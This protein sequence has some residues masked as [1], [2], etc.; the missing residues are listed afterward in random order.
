[1][2]SKRTVWLVIPLAVI[3]YPR[4]SAANLVDDKIDIYDGMDEH[5]ALY[6]R[7]RTTLHFP[8]PPLQ[9]DLGDSDNYTMKRSLDGLRA[10]IDVNPNAGPTNLNVTFS[11]ARG[12]LRLSVVHSPQ[13]ARAAYRLQYRNKPVIKPAPSA[14]T[15]PSIDW[16]SSIVSVQTPSSV[17]WSGS[18][19]TLELNPG[20]I[21]ETRDDVWMP[22]EV[23]NAGD[24]PFPVAR[25]ELL[26]HRQRIVSSAEVVKHSWMVLDDA[27]A[28]R[29]VGQGE[30]ARFTF[31]VTRPAAI[32]RGWAVRIVSSTGIKPA[33]F[34]WTP[35]TERRSTRGGFHDRISIAVRILGGAVK[36]DDGTVLGVEQQA[37]TMLQGLGA[38]VS[39]GRSRH[40]S[41]EVGVDA[42]RTNTAQIGNTAA[43]ATGGRL[44]FGGRV[45]TGQR[46]VTYARGGF[47][48]RL[49]RHTLESV[50]PDTDFRASGML[51][52]GGGV[53][54]LLNSR[55][56]IGLSMLG[57]LPIGGDPTGSTLEV[58]LHA[59]ILLGR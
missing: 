10:M 25:I 15:G 26:D 18:G 37:W 59:G 51:F 42:L 43:R 55:S 28:P 27:D 20:F 3:L 17:L 56:L 54:W 44:Y 50:E 24:Y 53:D 39:Y 11:D 48:I 32:A 6:H 38:W 7:Y 46:L 33:T 40:T 35:K 57:Y 5:V 19:H 16:T 12:A 29:A 4:D 47:G 58:G 8:T 21:V 22:F 45:H 41:L 14:Q 36:L 1:M 30:T 23:D 34:E 52:L 13:E 9:L 49:A 2:M 31:R